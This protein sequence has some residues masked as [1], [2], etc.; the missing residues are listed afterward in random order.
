MAAGTVLSG[1]VFGSGGA[2]VFAAMAPLA[3]IGLMLALAAARVLAAQPHR[4][5]EG[6]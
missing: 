4:A 5:G 3:A 6:G 2:L 1:V